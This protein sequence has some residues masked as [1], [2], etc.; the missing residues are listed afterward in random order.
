MEMQIPLEILNGFA[1]LS[2]LKP[3]EIPPQLEK[4][5]KKGLKIPSQAKEGLEFTSHL[6]EMI[7]DSGMPG[8]GILK[9]QGQSSKISL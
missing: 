2:E 3:L 9:L 5:V 1:D 7:Y 6:S 8:V 4:S